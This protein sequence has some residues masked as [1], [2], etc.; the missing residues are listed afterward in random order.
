MKYKFTLHELD[1]LTD[2]KW[3]TDRERRVLALYYVRGWH[4]ET[5]AAELEDR[6][7]FLTLAKQE[8]VHS[9]LLMQSAERVVEK[10][11]EN[12]KVAWKALRTNLME[13]RESLS[14]KINFIERQK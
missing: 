8:L 6:N 1:V 4:I 13:W 12:A 10:E 14:Q 3:L 5:V 2:S 7:M 9:E 11:E